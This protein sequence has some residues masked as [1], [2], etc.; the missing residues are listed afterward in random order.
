MKERRMILKRFIYSLVCIILVIGI[1]TIT[2]LLKSN[3]KDDLKKIR[4]AE[5]TH[6][7]FYAPQYLADALGYFKKEGLNVEFV[8]TPGADKVTSAVL[9]GDVEI[10]FCGSEATIYVYNNGE[11]DYL[12]NFAALTKKD[13]SFLV[14]R[15]KI[16]NFKVENLKGKHVIAGRKG[17]M[18]AMTLE[19]AINQAG[20]KTEEMN[21]DT[22]YDFSATSGA[23]IGGAGDFVALFEPTATNLV[24]EGYGYIVAS[25]GEMGGI[26]PYTGY[27]AKKSYIKNNKK[28]IASFRKAINKAL[29][30]V[31]GHDAKEI[32]SSLA[33][34]FPDTSINDLEVLVQNYLNIDAWFSNT[35]ILEEDFN[36]I[37]EIVENA[38][39]LT[40]KAPYDKLVKND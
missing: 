23:F 28:T 13:G 15:E 10:G 20:L 7:I 4:V 27:N 6:S 18:P 22:S 29:E 5:V 16:D 36:H 2:V 24:K 1:L 26:V 31:H 32:A 25:V 11:E 30:Y 9:S 21:F 19:Y 17:G 33:P 12:I 38:G 39:E 3:N 35:K 40:K 14:S 37:Q 8:L 34:Y